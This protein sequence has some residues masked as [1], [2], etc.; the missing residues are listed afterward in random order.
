MAHPQN[1]Y[2]L[3]S[4]IG[5]TNTRVALANGR[6]IIESTIRRYRNVEY[7]GLEQVLRRY[8]SDE[9]DVDPKSRMCSRGRPGS[10]WS[11]HHDQPRL[12]HRQRHTFARDQI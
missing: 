4:D 2:T 6:Q 8:I 9:N 11:R 7:T 10:R 3:V 1:I 12:D 5:G